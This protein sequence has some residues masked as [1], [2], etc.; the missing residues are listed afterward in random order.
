M[1]KDAQGLGEQ[2]I[3]VGLVSCAQDSGRT[4]YLNTCLHCLRWSGAFDTVT[5]PRLYAFQYLQGS[6]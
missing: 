5:L 2:F 6:Q 1:A 3:V 4:A